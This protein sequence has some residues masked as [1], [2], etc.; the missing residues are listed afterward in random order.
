MLDYLKEGAG[1]NKEQA[2]ANPA[3]SQGDGN[4]G[5]VTTAAQ[6]GKVKRGTY[7]LVVLILLGLGGLWMMAKKTAPKAA[8]AKSN[9]NAAIESAIAKLTGTKAEFFK[10]IDG[11]VTKFNEIANVKQVKVDELQKNPFHLENFAAAGLSGSGLS[12]E[13]SLLERERLERM[14]LEAASM[15]MKL[16]SII[17]GKAGNRCMIDDKVVGK[18]EKVRGWTVEEITDNS[19]ALR[20]DGMQIVLKISE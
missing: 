14:E 9:D 1:V 2:A 8:S 16:L 5:F 20:A 10:E 19:V 15:K 3:G 12:D 4:D 18:G 11:V 7:L 17:K 13:D 6:D